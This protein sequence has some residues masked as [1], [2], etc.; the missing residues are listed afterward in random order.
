MT[1]HKWFAVEHH[2]TVY[3]K[4]NIP[5]QKGKRTTIKMHRVVMNAQPGDIVDHIN[6]NGLD[7]RKENLRIVS[8]KLNARNRKAH[9]GSSSIYKGVSYLARL[10]KWQVNICE[11]GI[12]HYVGVYESEEQAARAYDRHA[13]SRFG[14][15]ARLNFPPVNSQNTTSAAI[16]AERNH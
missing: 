13:I 15:Y 10:G 11:D 7:N 6:G 5:A 2:G 14:Q 1:Y 3:A 16:R 9:A 4:T 8:N 12:N